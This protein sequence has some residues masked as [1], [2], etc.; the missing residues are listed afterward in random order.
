MN[1]NTFPINLFLYIKQKNLRYDLSL[2]AG[3]TILVRCHKILK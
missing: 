1:I 3:K 2:E